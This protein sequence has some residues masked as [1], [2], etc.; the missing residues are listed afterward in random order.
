MG[1][2]VEAPRGI[3]SIRE[4]AA[5]AR[6]SLW[7]VL[8]SRSGIVLLALAVVVTLVYGFA[9]TQYARRTAV[10]EARFYTEVIQSNFSDEVAGVEAIET[11]VAEAWTRGDFSIDQPIAAA[12]VLRS[13]TRNLRRIEG[14]LVAALDGR[15]IALQKGMVNVVRPTGG[16]SS[17]GL[18]YRFAAEGGLEGAP[19]VFPMRWDARLRPWF[20]DALPRRT[21]A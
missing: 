18:V 17:Q 5:G 21:A 19:N 11:A 6:P 1:D 15:T 20:T 12:Q 16:G 9:L 14:L 13:Y 10:G 7:W 4:R 8:T 3:A 2:E